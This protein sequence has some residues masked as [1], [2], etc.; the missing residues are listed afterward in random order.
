MKLTSSEDT[1][2]QEKRDKQYKEWAEIYAY[3]KELIKTDTNAVE[4]TAVKFGCSRN[5]VTMAI[6]YMIKF[7][8]NKC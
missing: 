3:W 7:E 5:K 8:K 4:L 2:L 6:S 1:R